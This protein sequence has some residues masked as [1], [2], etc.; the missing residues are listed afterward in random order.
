MFYTI[1]LAQVALGMVAA[2]C[3][4]NVEVL[5]AWQSDVGA[6][7]TTNKT[8]HLQANYSGQP[9]RTPKK[10]YFIKA[11]KVALGFMAIFNKSVSGL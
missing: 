6:L 8:Q 10:F 7:A 5:W 3:E 9:A 2:G 4:A 1:Y 11:F